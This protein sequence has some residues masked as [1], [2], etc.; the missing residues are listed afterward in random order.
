MVNYTSEA[1]FDVAIGDCEQ[2]LILSA[3]HCLVVVLMFILGD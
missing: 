3:W 2:H 1:I